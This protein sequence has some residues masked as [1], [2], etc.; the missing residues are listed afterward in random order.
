MDGEGEGEFGGHFDEEEYGG[1]GAT[2]DQDGELQ[3]T[4]E[5]QPMDI[6]ED[7]A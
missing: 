1:G 5:G 3:A 6:I 2:F 7:V 4:E